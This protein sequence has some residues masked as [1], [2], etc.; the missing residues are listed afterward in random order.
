[1]LG[2]DAVKPIALGDDIVQG[3][4]VVP[5]QHEYDGHGGCNCDKRSESFQCRP[6]C[7]NFVRW[8]HVKT[9]ALAVRNSPIRRAGRR[10]YYKLSPRDLREPSSTRETKGEEVIAF[11]SSGGLD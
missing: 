10:K 1:M 4:V 5:T 7:G 11:L 9:A 3:Q 8:R 2:Q 6:S